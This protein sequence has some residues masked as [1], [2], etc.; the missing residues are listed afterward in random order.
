MDL[1]TGQGFTDLANYGPFDAVINCAAISQPG[2]CE[3]NPDVARYGIIYESR[4]IYEAI[5][6]K[7]L[8]TTTSVCSLHRVLVNFLSH[9]QGRKRP[10]NAPGLLG[11]AAT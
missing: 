11:A 9:T 8:T 5:S 1:A 10:D 4:P 6:S 3:Q 7:P 2:V